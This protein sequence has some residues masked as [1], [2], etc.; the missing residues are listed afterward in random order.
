MRRPGRRTGESLLR[1]VA[2]AAGAAALGLLAVLASAH[3]PL[4]PAIGA[5]AASGDGRLRSTEVGS[6]GPT[7]T[8][9][10]T[11]GLARLT[12]PDCCIPIGW[13][14]D[15]RS[16]LVLAQPS[17][18]NPAL[19]LS[20]PVGGG[21]AEVAWERPA[22][23]SPDGSLAIEPEGARVRLTRRVG[24][25][26]W[27]IANA[28]RELRFAPGGA[29]VAWDV[30]SN[31]IAHP[32][33]REHAL[34]VA[35]VKGA[36]ARK[37]ATTIGG[38]LVG[39]AEGAQALIATGRIAANGQEGVWSIGLDGSSPRLIH[40][41]HR[42]RDPLLSP[43][44]GWVAFY[45][46]FTGDAGQNGLWILRLEGASISKI[47]PFG[48]YRWRDEGRLLLIPLSDSQP[49]ALFEIDAAAG[50]AVQLTNPSLTSLPIANADWLVSPDG[51]RMAFTSWVDRAVW[52]L[53]LPEAG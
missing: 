2:L 41:V 15:S 19:V 38:G 22:V 44:G 43:G 28:G 1:T 18:E 48:A 26:S 21:S 29:Q 16:L 5:E 11:T 33:V 39:W 25:V 17:P 51:T 45:A 4:E 7:P 3:A 37:L 24:D 9:L 46:A 8:P 40:Q 52:V 47:T 36:G 27:T 12:E 34:W 35:D 23:F 49:P 31:S 53:T 10:G 20:V 42:P 13:A 6:G 30:T 50:R 14:A 32:D